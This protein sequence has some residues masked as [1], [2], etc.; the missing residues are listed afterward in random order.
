MNQKTRTTLT[1]HKTTLKALNGGGGNMEFDDTND[2]S[3]GGGSSRVPTSSLPGVT[4]TCNG[5]VQGGGNPDKG[6]KF[7]R[8]WEGR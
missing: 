7:A 4:T 6:L 2:G 3:G 1:L 5:N 8:K